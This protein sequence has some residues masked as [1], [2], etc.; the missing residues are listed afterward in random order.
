MYST[1]FFGTSLLFQLADF[2]DT[3]TH[4]SFLPVLFRGTGSLPSVVSV[5]AA[6]VAVINRLEQFFAGDDSSKLG[7]D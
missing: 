2:H 6:A 5:P 3:P 7:A 1:I 4:L